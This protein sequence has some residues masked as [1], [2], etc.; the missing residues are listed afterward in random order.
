M[1]DLRGIDEIAKGLVEIIGPRL[2]IEFGD[3]G[4]LAKRFLQGGV[5]MYAYFDVE[6]DALQVGYRVPVDVQQVEVEVTI[7]AEES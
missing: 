2:E 1:I 7:V 4:R 6:F 5:E 3:T